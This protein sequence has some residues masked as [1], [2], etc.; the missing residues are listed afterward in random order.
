VSAVF[1]ILL[2]CAVCGVAVL[3][4]LGVETSNRSLEDIAS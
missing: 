3:Y 1:S 4:G 2:G